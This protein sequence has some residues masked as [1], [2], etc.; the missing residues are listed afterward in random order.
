MKS[1]IEPFFMHGPTFQNHTF[2]APFTSRKMNIGPPNIAVMAPTG[3]P[4]NVI[5]LA[6]QSHTTRMAAPHAAEQGR[7]CLRL[8]PTS[9]LAM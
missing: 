5:I 2:L 1:S 3:M 8:E 4:E 6:M 7:R 9:T